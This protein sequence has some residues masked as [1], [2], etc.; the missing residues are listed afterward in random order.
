MIQ[1]NP[2][3]LW[4]GLEMGGHLFYYDLSQLTEALKMNSVIDVAIDS[5]LS[6]TLANAAY[7]LPWS[8]KSSGTKEKMGV[9]A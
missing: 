6:A 4:Q 5:T 1:S 9:Q 7:V 8:T 2:Q 3:H